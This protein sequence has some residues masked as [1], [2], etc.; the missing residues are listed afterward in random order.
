M[1]LSKQ[2]IHDVEREREAW[3]DVTTL[4]A[5]LRLPEEKP[6]LE[7]MDGM[8]SQK[9]SP[10]ARHGGLQF[11]LGR[12]LY[13]SAGPS[14]PIRIFTETR[15]TYA[16]VSLVPDLSVFLRERVQKERDGSLADDVS[17]PPDIAVEIHSPSQTIR[18]QRERCR[19]YV[20]NGVRVSLLLLPRTET[21]EVFRPDA[22]PVVARGADRIDLG[23]IVPG[24]G[25]VV[26]ELFAI[27]HE[28]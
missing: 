7:F 27:L 4:A 13:D 10:K 15:E 9:V 11:E 6:A 14:R 1:A 2:H 5:F 24:L 26:A 12:L 19:W 22:E 18:G 28:D 8:V 16:D 25:F 17:I 3:A 23:D 20:D 21:V